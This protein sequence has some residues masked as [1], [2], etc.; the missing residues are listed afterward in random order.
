ML[1]HENLSPDRA[2]GVDGSKWNT[3]GLSADS[4]AG[5]QYSTY[6]IRDWKFLPIKLCKGVSN[7]TTVFLLN[8]LLVIDI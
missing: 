3:H 8:D 2:K 7:E 4:P 5:Q 6:S 1:G